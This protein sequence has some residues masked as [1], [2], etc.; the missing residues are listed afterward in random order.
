MGNEK[1]E[2][3]QA[4]KNEEEK[5]K[6]RKQINDTLDSWTYPS[7]ANSMKNIDAR[8]S[9]R[10]F[11]DQNG[12]SVHVQVGGGGRGTPRRLSRSPSAS[13]NRPR[14]LTRSI[15]KGFD[16]QVGT[17]FRGERNFKILL[18]DNYSRVFFPA[19]FLMF[20]ILY[21]GYYT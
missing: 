4:K 7:R 20:N 8:E 21:W 6:K 17:F 5:V 11:L 16:K 2:K 9:S 14:T 19:T 13:K 12:E 1:K 3:E 18:V 15:S 10:A